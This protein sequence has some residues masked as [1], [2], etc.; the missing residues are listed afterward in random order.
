MFTVIPFEVTALDAAHDLI[1][2]VRLGNLVTAAPRLDASPLPFMLDRARGGQGV[3]VGH[4]A[5]DNRQYPALKQ[6]PDQE[7]LVAFQ[8]PQT[9]VSAAWYRTGPRV[10][11]W[12]YTAAHVYGRATLIEDAAGLGRILAASQH[13]FSEPDNG[14]APDPGYVARLLPAIVGIEITI[15]R[16]EAQQRLGQDSPDADHEQVRQVL[17]QGSPA[18][19]AVAALMPARDA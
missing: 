15:D 12:Y 7:V 9:F 4:L 10:S 2:S 1:E 19:R 8:G 16:I 11:T 14:W 5:R 6:A 18:Q 17:G 3:L 13:D